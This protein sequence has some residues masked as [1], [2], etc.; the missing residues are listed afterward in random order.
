MSFLAVYI[1]YEF[2]GSLP[3]FNDAL[4][5]TLLVAIMIEL[6]NQRKRK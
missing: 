5:S 2:N 6:T 3:P 4:Q 1:P